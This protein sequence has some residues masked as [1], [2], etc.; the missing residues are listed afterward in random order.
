MINAHLSLD[1]SLTKDHVEKLNP[2]A[3]EIFQWM[4]YSLNLGGYVPHVYECNEGEVFF[5]LRRIKGNKMLMRWDVQR[6]L[7]AIA[8]YLF[9]VKQN[10]W[11]VKVIED[12]SEGKNY[13][14]FVI[15]VDAG[16]ALEKAVGG[17]PESHGEAGPTDPAQVEFE[18]LSETAQA[19]ASDQVPED[20]AP[21]SSW[22]RRNALFPRNQ[23]SQ[24]NHREDLVDESD[25]SVS[26]AEVR[27][28]VGLDPTSDDV[29]P[30]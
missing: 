30:N 28:L 5:V 12:V 8:N 29:L 10:Y 23:G 3:K 4:A 17:S 15:K 7:V 6:K 2:A 26:E 27:E 13:T 1:D 22:G 14:Y 9:R 19:V 21:V 20:A 11:P 16:K 24:A 18:P 25:R